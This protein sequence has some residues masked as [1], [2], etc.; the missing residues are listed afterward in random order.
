MKILHLSDTHGFHRHLKNLPMADVVVHSGDFCM[1]GSPEEAK[2]FI[3]WFQSLPYK[4]KIFICG[5]HDE[6]LF[7]ASISGLSNDVHYLCNSGV[8]LEDVRFYGV[9]MFIRGNH[10]ADY[11]NIEP[12]IDVLITHEP[13]YGILD[14]A[15][16]LPIR[17]AFS[18]FRRK[19]NCFPIYTHFFPN[20]R[21]FFP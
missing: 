20:N 17:P 4:H 1:F 12:N 3:E 5:N 2:D 6:C 11:K 21:H 18:F 19:R 14:T 13:P 15:S 8:T 9:T 10:D 16:R 7:N